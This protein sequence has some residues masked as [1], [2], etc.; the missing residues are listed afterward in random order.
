MKT[1]SQQSRN[2]VVSLADIGDGRGS[3]MVGVVGKPLSISQPILANET[4]DELAAKL[5]RIV[6]WLRGPGQVAR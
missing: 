2:L 1:L 5:E 4:A 3:L 6:D